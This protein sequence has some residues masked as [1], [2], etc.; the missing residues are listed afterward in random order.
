MMM[1]ENPP[2]APKKPS[3]WL[4][5][6]AILLFL[7]LGSY[8][9]LRRFNVRAKWAIGG[10]AAATVVGI[11]L[12]VAVSPSSDT[13]AAEAVTT[14]TNPGRPTK[15]AV[16]AREVKDMEGFTCLSTDTKFGRCPHNQYFGMKPAAVRAMKARVA[17]QARARAKAA[18]KAAAEAE[19]RSNAWKRGFTEVQDGIAIKWDNSVCDSS[20]LGCF[21]MRLVTRDGCD[22]LYVELQVQDAA[23]NAVGITNDTA[24]GLSPGQVALLDFPILEDR[25]ETARISQITCY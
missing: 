16:V 20:Y 18:A 14:S 25:G 19:R 11:A 23:G 5:A 13:S 8:L 22:S 1:M 2:H 3:G 12:L 21:G 24:S 6:V 7:P 17:R 9:L 4:I 10:A 15:A